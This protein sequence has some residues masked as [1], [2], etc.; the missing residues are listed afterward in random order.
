[1]DTDNRRISANIYK[2]STKGQNFNK[3]SSKHS[4]KCSGTSNKLKLK[5]RKN[6]F[7]DDS[8]QVSSHRADGRHTDKIV[9][10]VPFADP[11]I[12]SNANT[13]RGHYKHLLTSHDH[14]P[15]EKLVA[16]EPNEDKIKNK[17]SK[18]IESMKTTEIERGSGLDKFEKP[19]LEIEVDSLLKAKP[20][21]SKEPSSNNEF[22]FK[23]SHANTIEV[24]DKCKDLSNSASKTKNNELSKEAMILMDKLKIAKSGT[25]ESS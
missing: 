3:S 15:K 23:A 25:A 6:G 17:I 24:E 14:P 9:E 16:L 21:I 11:N 7:F 12:N 1:M 4:I 18:K 5:L 20:R 10:D 22:K 13:D 19:K 2:K 8:E